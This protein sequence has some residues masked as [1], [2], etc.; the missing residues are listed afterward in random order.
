TLWQGLIAGIIVGPLARL[1]LPGKQN[2]SVVMTILLGAI[3]A[4]G[5]GL[6]YEAFG[7]GETSGIDWIRLAIQVAV[8]AVVVLIYG[9]ARKGSSPAT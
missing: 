3:G 2:L 4:I 5:G 6:V 8:A 1:V 7:G 9:N